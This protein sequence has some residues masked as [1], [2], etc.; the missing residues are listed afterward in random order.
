VR[1]PGYAGTILAGIT[2]PLALAS[3]WALIPACIGAAGF[4]VRTELEDRTLRQDLDGYQEYADR[5]PYRLSPGI[6]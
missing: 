3:L 5:V 6:W 2:W 1:H 4:V